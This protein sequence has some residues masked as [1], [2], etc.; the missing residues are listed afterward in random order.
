M[1]ARPVQLAGV[2]ASVCVIVTVWPQL[3]VAVA[4]PVLDGS[5]EP[6][7]SRFLSGGQVISGAVVFHELSIPAAPPV[8]LAVAASVWVIVTVWPQLSVAVALPLLV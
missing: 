5:V 4:V 7:H 6:P 1:P 3:S 8:Q 2:A